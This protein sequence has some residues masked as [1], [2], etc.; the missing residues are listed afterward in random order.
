LIRHSFADSIRDTQSGDGS[1][2]SAFGGTTIT[3]ERGVSIRRYVNLV[4]ADLPA[5]AGKIGFSCWPGLANVRRLRTAHEVSRA[6]GL[7]NKPHDSGRE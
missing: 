7:R 2:A 6:L 3:I 4:K 5:D 1:T